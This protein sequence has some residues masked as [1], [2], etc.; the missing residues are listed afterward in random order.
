MLLGIMAAGVA[1]ALVSAQDTTRAPTQPPRPFVEGGVFDKPYLS[2]LLG[3]T[4]IGGYAEAHA[5]W[6]RADGA[7]EEAGFLLRRWNVFTA[8]QVSDFVRIAAELEFEE[9]GEEITVEFAAIDVG[10]HPALTV[11]AG[12]LLSPLGRFN[13]SHDSPRNEFTDRPL[14]STELLGVALSEPGLGVLGLVSLGGAARLTYELYAVNG[15]HDGLISDAAEGTRV[16]LG[17]RNVEDNNSSPALVGRMAWSP[18]VGYELGISSHRG[19]YNVY[20]SEGMAVDERRDLVIWVVD[21]E[22]RVAGVRVVGEAAAAKIDIPPGLHGIYA[23]RQRGLYVEALR[24]FGR[25]WVRTMPSSFFAAG[26]RL[27]LVDFDADLPGDVVR[28]VTVGLNFRPTQDTVLKLNFVRG[29][30]RDRFNNPSDQAGL[31]FSVAT[32]F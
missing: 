17:R 24:P 10:I 3:R 29:R 2:R 30:T 27:D 11:R 28:R 19:A 9:G 1:P 23:S 16:A 15:F 31:L 7:T 12:M 21:A 8:T 4:A 32:Y 26:A 25:A 5:R 14:V 18:R 20:R 22:A 13:L 6:E